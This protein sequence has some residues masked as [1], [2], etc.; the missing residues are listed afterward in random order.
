MCFDY[1]VFNLRTRRQLSLRERPLVAMDRTLVAYMELRPEELLEE[2]AELKRRCRLFQGDFT[3]LWHNSML[4]T[5][6]ERRLYSDALA[7]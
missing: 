5:R 4:V 3:L 1:P 6:R 2:V 7:L